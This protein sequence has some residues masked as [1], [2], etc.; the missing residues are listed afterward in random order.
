M[1]RRRRLSTT[2]GLAALAVG[3]IA[4]LLAAGAWLWARPD[5]P[6]GFYTYNGRVPAEA[7]VLLRAEAA[8]GLSVDGRRVWRILYT[9]TDAA[10]R[11]TV[12]SGLVAVGASDAAP[13]PVIAW[14]HGTTGVVPGCAPSMTPEPFAGSAFDQAMAA[15]W[16]YVA[17][18]YPGLGA[19]ERHAYLVG[20][21]SGRAVLDAVVAARGLDGIALAPTTVIW[22][23]SQGG[24]ASLWAAALAP[25]HAPE[26]DIRGV[27]ALAPASDLPAL[28]EQGRRTMF[29]KII[30][31]YMV[32][33]YRR[34]Y[35]Q[36][37]ID[38]QVAPR[39]RFLANDIAGRCVSG[40]KTLVSV[41]Q[42]AL[43]PRDGIFRTSPASGELGRLLA[44][45]TPTRPIA[46]PVLIAQGAADDL[47]LPH[48][49]AAYVAA[50]RRA[51]Q[52]IDYRTYPARD[53]I[54]VVAP[55]SPATTDLMAWTRERFIA[56]D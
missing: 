5:R 15:G 9:T 7:G 23:H 29:G 6:D 22:G 8:P 40:A 1:S 28:F 26:L 50:R 30:S 48:I 36:S 21:P 47:V 3:A 52:A 43:L 10:R 46:A 11:P 27:A 37:D 24:G 25:T 19:G 51:G 41:A 56:S 42:T 14:A 44:A 4:L 2:L 35:P 20:E 13:R 32:D 34:A 18:D 38:A 17:T 16:A 49:Q 53:H 54:S 31:A 39:A 55:D 45:N 33:A 12:A